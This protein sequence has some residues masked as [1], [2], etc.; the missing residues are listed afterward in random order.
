MHLTART[1]DELVNMQKRYGDELRKECK[2]DSILTCCNNPIL[3]GFIYYRCIACENENIAVD[4]DIRI[5]QV[6]T[7][8]ALHEIIEVLG[9]LFDNAYECVKTENSLEQRI[10]LEFKE[11]VGKVVFSVSNPA[12]YIPFSETLASPIPLLSPL[13][14]YPL[15]NILSISEK[16]PL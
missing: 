14:L 12:K 6:E 8:F 1:L 15:R 9:I 5:D 11:D 2:F 4:Y 7:C 10:K 3:A 16:R 13:L